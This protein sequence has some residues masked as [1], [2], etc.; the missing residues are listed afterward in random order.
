MQITI[1]EEEIMEAIYDYCAKQITLPAG[2]EY[3]VE[4]V[5]GRAPAGP[6]AIIDIV[7]KTAQSGNSA[8]RIVKDEAP[9][10]TP[11]KVVDESTNEK[12]GTSPE[13]AQVLDAA[14]I[15]FDDG[16]QD[17][18]EAEPPGEGP[19]EDLTGKQPGA[20]GVTLV[21]GKSLFDL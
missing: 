21:E 8:K 5:A 4:F 14:G 17:S 12:P 1:N 20:A 18:G 2:S 7:T 15:P 19:A 3:S 13:I 9:D 11:D 6:R 16:K 10:K